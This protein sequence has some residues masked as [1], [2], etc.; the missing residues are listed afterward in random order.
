MLSG[1]E[2]REQ[3]TN[4]EKI[5]YRLLLL[6]Y[7]KYWYFFPIFVII[8]F[9]IAYFYLWYVRPVFEANAVIM[10]K[11]EKKGIGGGND[12][13]KDLEAFGGNKIVEN[14]LE[15]LKSRSLM[16]KVVDGLNLSVAYFIE[17]T[18]NRS[19]E[20][21]GKNPFVFK[22]ESLKDRPDNLERTSIT[23]WDSLEYFLVKI[24]SMLKLNLK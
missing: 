17:N 15:I 14:E 21:F 22:I 24:S 9:A 8:S 16:Q 12:I 11:D 3:E 19:T 1:K 13:L 6:K 18:Y 2:S 7:L 4:L 20:V 23:G 5:D 10:I